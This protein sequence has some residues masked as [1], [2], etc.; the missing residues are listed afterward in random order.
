MNK[1]TTTKQPEKT[2]KERAALK[3]QWD[4]LDPENP[5]NRY[6]RE[7]SVRISRA[8]LANLAE[9]RTLGS[10]GEWAPEIEISSVFGMWLHDRIRDARAAAKRDDAQE[11]SVFAK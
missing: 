11:G 10:I 6:G 1:P 7:V 2:A 4:R 5:R 8:D 3:R 9:L